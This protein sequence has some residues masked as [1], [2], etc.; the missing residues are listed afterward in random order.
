MAQYWFARPAWLRKS[1]P[2]HYEYIWDW[3]W[4]GTEQQR[5]LTDKEWTK[6]NQI[7]TKYQ[8]NPV[9]QSFESAVTNGQ[10]LL[11]TLNDPSWPSDTAS[12]FMFMKSLDPQSVV[13]ESEFA[14]AASSAWLGGKV[15]NIFTKLQ[16]WEQLTATQREQF[17]KI[18]KQFLKNRAKSY[19]RI[20][21]DNIRILRQ[22]W[23]PT[24]Y[25]PENAASYLYQDENA[26]TWWWNTGTSW[27]WR[28][29]SGS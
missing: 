28:R 7:Y 26:D 8:S 4:W 27:S 24:S 29:R 11:S 2:W 6:F 10:N 20:Y 12:I 19:E 22:Q 23:I 16:N 13:R 9:V 5:E 3:Q 14:Q 15:S 18:A 17:W 1:D 21:N 25:F